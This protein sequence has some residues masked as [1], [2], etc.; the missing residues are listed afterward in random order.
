MSPPAMHKTHGGNWCKARKQPR[1]DRLRPLSGR[2]APQPGGCRNPWQ[3]L[4]GRP[5]MHAC[6][7]PGNVAPIRKNGGDFSWDARGHRSQMN[8]ACPEGG[9][10]PAVGGRLWRLR[11]NQAQRGRKLM[12]RALGKNEGRVKFWLDEKHRARRPSAACPGRPGRRPANVHGSD[13]PPAGPIPEGKYILTS[14]ESRDAGAQNNP[15]RIGV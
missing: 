1:L 11:K 9:T 12:K 7:G 5:G 8:G 4:R 15:G 13:R 14:S 2:G 6:K 10:G 3:P